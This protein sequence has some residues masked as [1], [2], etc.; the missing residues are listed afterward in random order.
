M[1]RP[2][3]SLALLSALA[4]AALAC[5][6]G[7]IESPDAARRAA[8]VRS[9]RSGGDGAMTVL[10][11]A[12]RDG[13]PIVRAAAAESYAARG[14]PAAADALGKLLLDP[15]PAVAAVAARGLAAMPAEPR[16]RQQ[17]V[18]AYA[19]ATPGGRAAIAGALDCIGV[20]LREAVEAE[21]RTL[22]DR[23]IST[24]ERGRGGA[25]AGA[26]E[27]IGASGR[28]DAVEKLLAFVDPRRS[29]DRALAEAAARGLGESGDFSARPFLEALVAEEDAGLAEAAAA[30]LGRLGDPRAAD[31]LA[32]AGTSESARIAAA[33]T[34]ALALLPDAPEVG[35]ALCDLAI[36]AADPQ[37]ASRAARGARLRDADCPDRPFLA[38]LGRPGA[39]AALAA[40]AELRLTGPAALAATDRVIAALERSPEPGVRA[41][42]AR[43]LAGLGT[44][45]AVSA[46]DRRTQAIVARLVEKRARWVPGAAAAGA[47]PEWIDPVSA[48]DARE[49]GALL[50]ATGRLARPGAEALLLA[51]ARDGIAGVR[52]GAVEG[53]GAL[54]GGAAIEAVAAALVDPEPEVR[55]VA[56]EGLGRAGARGAP[57]LVLAAREAEGAPREWRS[58]LARAL[59][60]TG[61]AE[62]IPALVAL[63]DGS[64]AAAAA[65]ALSRIGAPASIAPLAEYLARPE[66]AG[67]SEAIEALAQLAAREAG[68]SI[69]AL[70]TDDCPDVRAA[71]ARA[72]GRLRHE[73]S[74]SRLESLRSDYFGRVRRAAVEALAKFSSGVPR[75][76]R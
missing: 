42:A 5:G 20:S 65:A 38:K 44:T 48:D 24:L 74:A 9:L 29:P 69:A 4:T 13:S 39:E 73:P 21:A 41:A 64:S 16:A 11:V 15:D 62:A 7:D 12:Q 47:V 75:A 49:A 8:A 17:L 63:L 70:L 57:S 25:R 34:D 71:A 37:V 67:R 27:E 10:L 55:S 54:G 46:V 3:A 53:L 43:V 33:T 36:R 35:V 22:W 56:A 68:P 40:L 72:L 66:A 50:A 2:R 61:S 18:L 52:A 31:A 60:E 30:G 26:A 23:N 6:R 51:H 32:A 58:V 59:G 28:A 76:R 19:D 45:Q 14:G 1:R